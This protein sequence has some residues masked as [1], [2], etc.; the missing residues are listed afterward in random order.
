MLSGKFQSVLRGLQS[1]ATWLAVLLTTAMA[2][3]SA[4]CAFG[5]FPWPSLR[6]LFADGMSTDIGIW[7]QL[8]VTFFLILVSLLLPA[9]GRMLRLERSHRSFAMGVQDVAHAYRLA[10]AADRAGVFALSGE[11]EAVRARL[12]HLRNHPDLAQLEPELLQLAAQMSFIT[13][14]IA[15]TYSDQKVARARS[16]LAQRQEEVQASKDRIAIAR[17]TVDE[18]RRW[19]TDIEAEE[20]QVEQQIKRLEGDLREILPPLGYSME[21]EDPRDATVVQ[22][23]KPTK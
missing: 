18:L 3:Y 4:A 20:R 9:N 21:L 16:F 1:T 19:L 2:L 11:F 6:V 7:L 5:L 22:L 12:E 15:Q 23:P 17:R 10:H 8:G 13:R 14:D